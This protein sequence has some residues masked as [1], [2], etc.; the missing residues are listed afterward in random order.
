LLPYHRD[1][2][3]RGRPGEARAAVLDQAQERGL[4][5]E[6]RAVLREPGDVGVLPARRATG[7][8]ELE[9]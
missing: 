9:G 1:C 2:R 3:V 8:C 7:R 6:R 5:A 4:S